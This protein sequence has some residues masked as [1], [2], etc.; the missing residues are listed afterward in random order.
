MSYTNLYIYK[1]CIEYIQIPRNLPKK[2]KY[3]YEIFFSKTP[4]KPGFLVYIREIS[5]CTA[6]SN[7]ILFLELLTFQENGNE[8]P[9]LQTS[10]I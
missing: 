7:S 6:S 10:V 3:G 1:Y 2:T 4:T 9:P 5:G 8:S